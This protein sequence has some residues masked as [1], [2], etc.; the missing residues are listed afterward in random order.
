MTNPVVEVRDLHK[1][2]SMSGTWPWSPTR[3]VRAV[4]GVSFSVH[5]GEVIASS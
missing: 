1:T 5:P 3:D 2:F 4:N